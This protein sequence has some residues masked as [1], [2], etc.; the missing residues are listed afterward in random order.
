MAR[1][2]TLACPNTYFTHDFARSTLVRRLFAGLIAGA[3]FVTAWLSTDLSAQP[4]AARSAS[5]LSSSGQPVRDSAA[6]RARLVLSISEFQSAWQLAWR[7]SESERHASANG[8]SQLRI[9]TPLIHCHP[10]D[11]DSQK[12]TTY[13]H[14]G[15]DVVTQRDFQFAQIQ[16]RNTMFAV[17]P[18]WLFAEPVPAARDERYGRDDALVERLR[19]PIHDA[20]ALLLSELDAAANNWP[21]DG[22]ISGQ[23][24]RFWLDEHDPTTALAAANACKADKWWCAALRGYVRGRNSEVRLAETAFQEMRSAMTPAQLCAWDDVRELLRESERNAYTSLN[25]ASRIAATAKLWWLADPLFRVA[26][27]ERQVEQELRRIEI[28]LHSALDQDERYSWSDKFGGDA[29][30]TL[31]QRYGWPGYTGWGGEYIDDDHTDYLEVRNS[32]RSSPYTTFEYS[33]DRARLLPSWNAVQ[34]P[35]SAPESSWIL[36]ND[37][38]L[39][40][41]FTEWWPIE[42]FRTPRR[43]V[44]LPEGQHAMLRRDT[45]IRVAATVTL[46]HRLLRDGAAMDVM[47]VSSPSSGKVD[48]LSRRAIRAGTIGVMQGMIPSAPT[49]LG[50]EALGINGRLTDAR[51]RFGVTPPPTLAAMKPG[52]IG[53]SEPVL[54]DAQ[55]DKLDVTKPSEALLDQMLN[56]TLLDSRHRR[57]GVYWETYGI[58]PSDT[59]TVSVRVAT[60]QQLSAVRRLGMALNVA[61]NPNRE[62]VQSWTEP[63]PRRSTQTLSGR[64]PVT[65]RAILLNLSL[66]QTDNYVLEVSVERKDGTVATAR[67]RITVEQ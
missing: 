51:A 30:R 62:V 32:P 66:L 39:G 55:G 14:S 57:V 46:S 22:W 37:N 1:P 28:L 40:Q 54:L 12:V 67:R 24:V 3:A 20:R 29:L 5:G 49:V 26:G 53:V 13:W 61:S 65:S 56:T 10:T 38:I 8:P 23:R 52:E 21:A 48:S 45:L 64:V 2:L 27:N 50:V 31:V 60:D 9:R 44:L 19:V 36:T 59:V 6:A 35:F 15:D 7:E 63:D 4:Y 25:C 16:S 43:L 34:S 11:A 42:H 41:P 58:A 18:T 47:F 17:C 33:I